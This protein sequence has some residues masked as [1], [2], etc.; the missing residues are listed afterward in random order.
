MKKDDK[1][2]AMLMK[3]ERYDEK[4]GILIY[5]P[6]MIITDCHISDDILESAD[7]EKYYLY[8]DMNII[9][10]NLDICY[11]KPYSQTDVDR[12][13]KNRNYDEK[14]DIEKEK[15]QIILNHFEEMYI[16][17]YFGSYDP[18]E[19]DEKAKIKTMYAEE[20]DIKNYADSSWFYNFTSTRDE[21]Y[22][23]KDNK[24][25]DVLEL[26]LGLTTRTISNMIDELGKGKNKKIISY[27]SRGYNWLID[28]QQDEEDFPDFEKT[29]EDLTLEEKEE[30][31]K[32]Y[33]DELNSMV[34][35]ENIKEFVN[36][37]EKYI[38]YLKKVEN[39]TNF[40]RPSLHM[41][42]T[43]NPGTG[44][45]TVAR[46][47][48]KIFYSFGYTQNDKFIEITTKDIIGG[49]VGDTAL[50]ADKLL[51]KYRGGVVFIDEAYTF[52]DP[53]Q[54]YGDEALSLILKEMERDGTVYIFAGYKD[55]MEHFLGMNPGLS[56][57]IRYYEEFNDYSEKE[58][59]EMFIR[60]VKKSKLKLEDGLEEKIL[61]II[62][63]AKTYDNFGNGR[64][65]DKLFEKIKFIHATNTYD[66]TDLE[67]LITITEK[68]IP[69]SMDDL[70]YKRKEKNEIGFQI[71]KK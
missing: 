5:K 35:I 66:S 27:L 19:K 59:L 21:E 51:K 32:P 40:E 2:A 34:G 50:K 64:F 69:K 6:Y 22:F 45:T 33:L 29:T 12:I 10:N 43:G 38:I 15:E 36:N 8:N 4:E 20:E 58:L 25:S 31:V 54:L 62:M 53:G 3:V 52:A 17:V 18:N 46:I 60:K 61:E 42:F 16:Y 65:I 7:G 24:D 14:V 37:L 70:L 67:K 56:S 1:Y 13:F 44:K 11:A 41:F 9:R 68:D 48:S 39:D 26:K 57:R 30:M 55:E 63:K 23:G 49:Y 28:E 47:L 71:Q